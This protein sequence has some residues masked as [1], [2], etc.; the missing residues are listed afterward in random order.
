MDLPD[1][2][3]GKNT[4]NQSHYPIEVAHTVLFGTS[5]GINADPNGKALLL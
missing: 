2:N 5:L 4:S 1:T 3:R